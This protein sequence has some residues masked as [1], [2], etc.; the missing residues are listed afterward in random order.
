M[1]D[2]FLDLYNEFISYT[3]KNDEQGARDFLVNNLQKFPEDVQDRLTFIFFE[4]AIKNEAEKIENIA[5][6][7]KQGLDTINRI[8]KIKKILE[9]KIKAENLI[10]KLTKE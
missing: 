10:S 6:M 1:N 3:D 5:S 2:K 4:E 8:D 7:Q 9:D